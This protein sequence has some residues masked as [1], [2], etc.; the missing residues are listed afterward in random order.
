MQHCD[1]SGDLDWHLGQAKE[2][3]VQLVEQM[4]KGSLVVAHSP[5]FGC[6][7][8]YPA[9]CLDALQQGWMLTPRHT[10][11]STSASKADIGAA[12]TPEEPACGQR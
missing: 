7:G 5:I 11:N 8:D 1:N 12:G 3:R 9:F 6:M 2:L 10:R 4:A